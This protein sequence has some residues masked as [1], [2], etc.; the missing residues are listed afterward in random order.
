[1]SKAK[2]RLKLVS[3]DKIQEIYI[4]RPAPAKNVSRTCI[5]PSVLAD[6]CTRKFSSHLHSASNVVISFGFPFP[7]SAKHLRLPIQRSGHHVTLI[8]T[9]G[10]P[11]NGC[12]CNADLSR[13][14]SG[15][16]HHLPLRQQPHWME[17]PRD[18]AYTC[19]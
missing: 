5:A 9:S 15:L 14:S 7:R 11:C 8:S 10:R 3:R 16:D 12:R 4:G 1:M 6:F 13:R 18:R 19:Q 2:S 17:F